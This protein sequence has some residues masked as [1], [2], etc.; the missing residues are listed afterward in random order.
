ML[1]LEFI[2]NT[3]CNLGCYYCFACLK[4]ENDVI[5]LEN[6]KKAIDLLYEFS[7]IKNDKEIF[8]K[9]YGGE[10]LLF[11]ERILEINQYIKEKNENHKDI[12]CEI[13]IITNAT[14]LTKEFLDKLKNVNDKIRFTVS[15]EYSEDAHNKIRFY[16]KDKS[17]SFNDLIKNIS[18][19]ESFQGYK[20]VHV[21]TVLSPD[22]LKNVDEFINF[23]EKY[24]ELFQFDLVP[25][26]DYTFVGKEHLIKNMKKLFDYY[27]E[28]F[29]KSDYYHVGT[30]QQLRS[31]FSNFYKDKNTSHCHAGTNQITVMPNGDVYPCSLFFHDKI[32]EYKYGS[33]ETD[34]FEEIFK[35]RNLLEP[36][37]KQLTKKCSQCNSCEKNNDFGCLGQCIAHKL[38]K[39]KG[40]NIE[41]VCEYNIEF[42]KQTNRFLTELENKENLIKRA[43]YFS[44]NKYEEI[45]KDFIKFLE[46]GGNNG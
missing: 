46:R 41:S 25:M 43:N 27:L 16:K 9:I 45:H 23:M 38:K 4:K 1:T 3:Q 44:S 36:L 2:T 30:F 12:N 5:S 7:K 8:V 33:L 34:S 19:L 39:N 42:G 32:T 40:K 15:L 35:K 6:A 20:R 24:K 31:L 37:F 10:P 17:G 26:F 11:K 29:D 18:Y 14:E 13:A 22:L 21:Q 28:C